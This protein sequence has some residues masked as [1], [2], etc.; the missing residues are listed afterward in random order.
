M[1]TNTLAGTKVFIV[2]DNSANLSIAATVLRE[3]GATVIFDV[4]G[5]NPVEQLQQFPHMDIILL[6][7]NL[8][9]GTSGFDIYDQIKVRPEL[10]HVPVIAVSAVD[11]SMGIPEARQRGF[12]GF[13]GKPIN[14]TL[15]PKQIATVISGT[16]VWYA[17]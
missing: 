8:R 12:N 11:P 15:F 17:R 13:I 9:D 5:F 10:A 2:E 3:A 4:I 16:E 6:D 7:L 1:S 14:I